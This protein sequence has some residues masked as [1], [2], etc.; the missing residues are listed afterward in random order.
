MRLLLHH[1]RGP[2][3]FT[4]L[5]TV[6]G[7][8][9]PTFQSSCEKLGLLELD[10]HWHQTLNDCA[11]SRMPHHLRY[12]FALIISICLP[13]SPQLLWDTFRN[14]LSED[15][16]HDAQRINP[17]I[18]YGNIIYNTALII[19]EDLCLKMANKSLEQLGID[20]PEREAFDAR[21]REYQREKCYDIDLLTTFVNDNKPLLI[22]NQEHAFNIVTKAALTNSGG[23]YFLDAPGGTGKTFVINLILAE[24]RRRGEIAIAVASSGIAATLLQGGRTSHSV[25]QLPLDINHC[26]K[27]M[28]N[29]YKSSGKA[30]LLKNCKLIV[31]DECTMSH[32][33]ALE[34]LDETLRDYRN[35]DVL[36]GGVVVLLAGDFRQTLPII[37]KS[38]AADEIS[39]CL[40]SSVLW[41][42]VQSLSLT[43]NMRVH[44]LNDLNA[45]QF[46]N[47]LL[48]MG[49]GLP[50][51]KDNPFSF[52]ENFCTIVVS[53][54]E[55]IEK[56]FPDISKNFL[57]KEWIRER[58]ILAPF[59]DDVCK[60]NIEIQA[61]I[62]YE[63]RIYRSIDK[64]M[65][66]GDAINYPTEFL[67]SLEVNGMPPH[68]LEL[69]I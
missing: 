32:R 18:S 34:A 16:L 64:V 63:T 12:L 24:I 25:F 60:L 19:I 36:M 61:A 10:T 9:C 29:M 54:D 28:C 43:I 69:K 11:L 55:L 37:P 48:Q 21:D 47:Q 38:T 3:C 1:V 41:K 67:N 50:P 8:V 45:E 51:F 59:N 31:W 44:L 7:H 68:L 58:A 42:H 4:D 13:S 39:A 65:E 49:N 22:S 52:P 40:K 5:R 26:E 62:P 56:V 20:P 2:K 6:F 35:N 14:E 66:E 33:K 53:S 57:N 27:A 23:I 30:K 15:I 46:A 17:S